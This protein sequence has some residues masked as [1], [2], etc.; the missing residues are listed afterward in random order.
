LAEIQQSSDITY[1]IYDWGRLGLDGEPRTLHLEEAARV[2]PPE[3]LPPCPLPTPE[4]G[5]QKRFIHGPHF[6][7]DQIE[8]AEGGITPQRDDRQFGI[9]SVLE[10]SAILQASPDETDLL[11][12]QGDTAFVPASVQSLRVTSRGRMWGLWTQPSD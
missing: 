9:F 3:K 5:I 10:G 7:L 2:R 11:L 6:V 4:G 8:L 1:R 12:S